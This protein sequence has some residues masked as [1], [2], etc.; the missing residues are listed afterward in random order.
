MIQDPKCIKSICDLRS[1]YTSMGKSSDMNV[2][3]S[4]T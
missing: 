4:W 2:N 1:P 3:V